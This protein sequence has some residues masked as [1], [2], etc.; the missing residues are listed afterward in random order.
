MESK[1]CLYSV[2]ELDT[3]EFYPIPTLNEVFG[4][5]RLSYRNPIWKFLEIIQSLQLGDK[6]ISICIK[7]PIKSF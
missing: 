7:T 3:I 5:T 2:R 1:S 4:R 6:M